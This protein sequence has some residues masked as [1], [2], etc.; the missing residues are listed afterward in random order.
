MPI[1]KTAAAID[2][3]EVGAAPKLKSSGTPLVA[4]AATIVRARHVTAT[5]ALVTQ[6]VRLPPRSTGK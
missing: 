4:V 3:V 2:E 1:A 5:S 6:S